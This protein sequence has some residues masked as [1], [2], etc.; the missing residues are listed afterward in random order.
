MWEATAESDR[1]IPM[2]K[3]FLKT[4]DLR[5]IEIMHQNFPQFSV[6]ACAIAYALEGGVDDVIV[7][8][9]QLLAGLPVSS[10]EEA[11]AGFRPILL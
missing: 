4:Q 10:V 9:L 3:Q 1:L 8:T 2:S 7:D 5:H 6:T 11:A